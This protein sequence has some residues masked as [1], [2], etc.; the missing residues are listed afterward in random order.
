MNLVRAVPVVFDLERELVAIHPLLVRRLTLVLR[1]LDDA[2]DVAQAAFT[3]AIER[4][5]TFRGGDARAWLYTI[6]MRLALN[7]LRR[8]KRFVVL[9]EALEPEWAMRSEP[10]LWH[11]LAELDPSHRAALVLTTLDGYTHAEV[12][13]VLGVPEGTVSSWLSRSKERLRMLLGEPS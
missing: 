7:E 1:N 10:D 8:R 12:A 11:A 2:Q 9:T 6:G 3:R 5:A 4:R 13:R